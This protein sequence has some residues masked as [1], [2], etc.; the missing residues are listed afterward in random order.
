MSQ[1]AIL[2]AFADLRNIRRGQG[3]KHSVALCLAIFTLGV[4]AGNQGFLA[5]GDWIDSYQIQLNP[6]YFENRSFSSSGSRCFFTHRRSLI[7]R[8]L[9]L[10]QA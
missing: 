2:E 9:I 5:I 1:I 3:R 7:E 8:G 10:I 6:I 4:A